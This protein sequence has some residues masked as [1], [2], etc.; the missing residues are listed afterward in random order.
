MVKTVTHRA[1]DITTTQPKVVEVAVE[2]E[3]QLVKVCHPMVAMVVTTQVV[4]VDQEMDVD[5]QEV[6]VV[7][8]LVLMVKHL[9]LI[10]AHHTDQ[11]V[12]MGTI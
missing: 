10:M 2:Q 1:Q 6:D 11:V 9:S 3:F 5:P 8:I 12:I 7:E 4:M